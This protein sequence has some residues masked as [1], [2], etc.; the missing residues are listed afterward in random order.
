MD[1]AENAGF[2][3]STSERARLIKLYA[4]HGLQKMLDGIESCVKHSAPNL[5]YLEACM[6]DKPK[7]SAGKQVAAQQYEQRDY[8]S[9]QDDAM[10]RM[11]AMGGYSSA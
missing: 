6:T 10:K 5:A 2:K 11:L 1:A 7:K 3:C 4:D 8:G 9:E